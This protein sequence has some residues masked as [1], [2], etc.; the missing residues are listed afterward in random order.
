MTWRIVSIGNTAKLD[1]R[2]NYLVVRGKEL[3][4][5]HLSEISV[6]IIETTAVSMTAAL[7]CELIKRKIKVI[8]CDEKR[9]PCGEVMPYYG[10]HDST[11]KLRVQ[12]EW[13]E[14]T[15]KQ[16]WAEIIHHKIA[17]QRNLLF[18][19]GLH[20]QASLLN[21]YIDDIHP[22][23][24]TN[25]EG[26][27]AKVYFNALFGMGFSR[28][29]SSSINACLNYGYAVLLSAVN[30]DIVSLGYNTQLG[31]FHDNMFNHFNLGS[32][33]ME[34]LRPLV[35][36]FVYELQPVELNSEM[37]KKLVDILNSKVIVEDKR[38]YLNNA[39]KIYCKSVLDSMDNDD[40]NML[41]FCEY[42]DT[43]Y[44]GD[45]LL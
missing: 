19:A 11:D 42:E 43:G 17:N 28:S 1:L 30:R 20:D 14:S 3:K 39:M 10:R 25:R 37:K 23:D 29:D 41:R 22:G 24:S 7:V 6:L 15:K 32:D 18:F 36:R 4:K 33:I 16:I 2:M 40:V 12:I 5:I 27:A 44:E 8:F 38:N 13:K 21:S 9:N 31:I 35:D 34:P 26:H 45:S